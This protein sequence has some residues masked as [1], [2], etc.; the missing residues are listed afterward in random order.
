M[1]ARNLKP[2]FFRNELLGTAEPLI[3]ILFAGLWCVADRE[4]RL[5]D[6]P[7]RLCAELFAYRRSVTAKKVDKMLDWLNSQRFIERFVVDGERYIQVLEFRKHQNP[8]THEAPSKIPALR[9]VSHGAGTVPSTI[10]APGTAPDEHGAQ[11][12]TSTVSRPA[13][14]SSLPE[15]KTPLPPQ[16]GGPGLNGHRNGIGSPRARGTN[17]RALARAEKEAALWAPLKERAALIGFREPQGG[18]SIGVYETQLRI[19]EHDQGIYR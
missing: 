19:A 12:H 11:H 17:P 15:S 3:S 8:H 10:Q 14:R 4:G 5:E 18:E 9:S 2:G 13:L 7:L 16:S 1:R 6:K